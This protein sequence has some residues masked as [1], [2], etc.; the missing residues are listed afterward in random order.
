MMHR[1][2]AIR[3][4]F[5]CIG[6]MLVSL[7]LSEAA[8]SQSA[9][10]TDPP[11]FRLLLRLDGGK[12]TY[13]LAEPIQVEFACY[14]DNQQQYRSPC[15]AGADDP[16]STW[17]ATLEVTA[18]NRGARVAVDEV[19]TRWIKRT[20][21]PYS[22]E[23]FDPPNYPS[24]PIVGTE[25]RWRKLILTGH[26]P[27]SGGR[28]RIRAVTQIQTANSNVPGG[29]RSAPVEIEVVDDQEWR[30]AVIR[31][32]LDA[33]SKLP[34]YASDAALDAELEKLRYMPDLD[35]LEWIVSQFGYANLAES[36]PDR[37]SVAKFLRQYLDDNDEA[38][39]DN[40]KRMFHAVL[41]LEL[42]SESPA[43]YARAV[44]FQDALGKPARRDLADLRAWLLPRYRRL[45]L[46][47][48]NS[49]VTTYRRNTRSNVDYDPEYKAEDLVRLSA[50]EC[51]NTKPFLSEAELR[52]F[53]REAGL[54]QK[55]I[56]EQIAQMLEARPDLKKPQ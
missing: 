41:A 53:M 51:I 18:L 46:D 56:D 47:I 42:A 8:S 16:I 2:T 28:F 49:N 35:V 24:Y 54:N 50:P 20:L 21:C 26:Y 4:I 10:L 45:M 39:P 7:V 9:S 25:I 34:P 36:H 17:A 13:K 55:F 5:R 15:A 6:V 48:A 43:L 14:S 44:K 30:T 52:R 11:G 27:M 23:Y 40:F 31:R 22:Q 38:L 19:E 37:A 12:T 3:T 33:I 29:A 1:G 32:T